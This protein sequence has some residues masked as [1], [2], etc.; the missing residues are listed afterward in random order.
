MRGLISP[1]LY[2]FPSLVWKLREKPDNLGNQH[3]M[4]IVR[5]IRYV[6]ISLAVISYCMS[7]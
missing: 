1:H 7:S 2:N 4:W 6:P 3:V 5:M